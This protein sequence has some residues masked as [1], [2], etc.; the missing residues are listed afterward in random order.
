MKN[1]H[2]LLA[3][4]LISIATLSCNK[5]GCSDPTADNYVK[6]VKKAQ[7]QKCQYNGEGICGEG[8]SFCFQID[9][10]QKTGTAVVYQTDP[11]TTIV[12]W[13]NGNDSN[14]A[15]YM[16][17][18]LNFPTGTQD[19]LNIGPI[20]SSKKFQADFYSPTTGLIEATSGSLLIKKNNTTDGIIATFNLT[21][22]TGTQIKKGNI[23][24]A[25]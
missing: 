11:Q 21:L 8:I 23:Y 12:F 18:Q 20:G 1:F 17:I 6:N 3:V 7:D 2:S 19:N 10:V 5:K 22:S 9:N 25:K 14:A 4:L 13:A 15:G 16:D 24:K